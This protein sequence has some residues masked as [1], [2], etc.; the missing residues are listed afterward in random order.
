M[1][2]RVVKV[3]HKSFTIDNYFKYL[4]KGQIWKFI[5]YFKSDFTHTFTLRDDSVFEY[6]FNSAVG[7]NLFIGKFEEIEVNWFCNA[8][9]PGD[10]V[11]DIGANGGL[12]TLLASKIV[13]STGHVYAFE[14]GE[15]E[16]ALL[17]NNL[18][19][20]KV[21]NVTV[22]NQAVSDRKS[23]ANFVVSQDGAMNSLAK[24][25]HIYQDVIDTTTVQTTSLDIF[26]DEFNIPKVDLIKIDVEG[27]EH[28]VLAGMKNLLSS[29]KGVKVLFECADS[30]AS[31]FNYSAKDLLKELSENGLDIGFID[32]RLN[33]IDINK[34][35]NP[36][37]IGV[38][39]YNFIATTSS[40]RRF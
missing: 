12:Y 33:I 24:N 5:V 35:P 10:I 36:D 29:S 32:D 37:E 23:N 31:G 40:N 20:N 1:I 25:T 15:R 16:L 6:P 17:H 28:L 34:Y 9:K 21:S 18:E 39:V 22:I 30:T 14:P 8:L 11:F 26:I 19:K 7:A 13:G 38:K 4:V 27:A 3:I 2:N